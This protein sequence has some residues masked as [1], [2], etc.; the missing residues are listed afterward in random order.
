MLS[1]PSPKYLPDGKNINQKGIDFGNDLLTNYL[2]RYHTAGDASHWDHHMLKRCMVE[3]D[4][5]VFP[6]CNSMFE[7]LGDRVKH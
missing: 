3:S 6:V 1:I 5:N 4:I 7:E 2:S